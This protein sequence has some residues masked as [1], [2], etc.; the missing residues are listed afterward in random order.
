MSDKNCFKRSRLAKSI[1]LM[2]GS[3]AVLPALAQESEVEQ[4]QGSADEEV[5]IVQGIR[6]SLRQALQTKRSLDVVADVIN[7]DDVGKLPDNNI[8]E[9]LSR[10]PGVQVERNGNEGAQ[11]QLRGLDSV[12]LEVNGQTLASPNAEPQASSLAVIPSQLFRRITVLK[13]FS[14]DQVEGGLGGTVKFETFRPFDFDEGQTFAINAD[15]GYSEGAEKAFPR[16]NAYLSKSFEDT[17]AGDFGIL[18]AGGFDKRINLTRMASVSGYNLFGSPNLDVDGDGIFG[19]SEQLACVNA[20]GTAFTPDAITGASS[21]VA[22]E[23][24][25]GFN[26]VND[27]QDALYFPGRVREIRT[28]NRSERQSHLLT[29]QWRPSDSIEVIADYLRI[30][31]EPFNVGSDLFFNNQVERN[32]NRVLAEN[33]VFNRETRNVSEYFI[34]DPDE[35]APGA[36][37][38]PA[39]PIGANIFFG[40][41]SNAVTEKTENFNLIVDF[42][43]SDSI[44]GVVRYNR[45]EGN[46]VVDRFAPFQNFAT[47]AGGN[48]EDRLTSPYQLVTVGDQSLGLE[49]FDNG[50]RNPRDILTYSPFINGVDS[51]LTFASNEEDSYTADFDWFLDYGILESLEFGARTSDQSSQTDNLSTSTFSD[52]GRTRVSFDTLNQAISGGTTI[53]DSSDFVQTGGLNLPGAFQIVNPENFFSNGRREELRAFLN[54]QA[55]NR[56]TSTNNRNVNFVEEEN[57]AFYVKGNFAGEIGDYPY[58]ASFGLRYVDITRSSSSAVEGTQA[59]EVNYDDILPTLNVKVDL[60]DDLVFRLGAARNFSRYEFNDVR[61]NENLNDEILQGS[62]GNGLLLPETV[63][64]IDLSLEYYPTDDL[65][66]AAA[67]Y[68]KTIE[69]F[70]SSS[71]T[72][73]CRL[74]PNTTQ[75]SQGDRESLSPFVSQCLDGSLG[76]T[77]VPASADGLI[78][79]AQLQSG[80]VAL[81][82]TFTGP[83]N[84]KEDVDLFGIE[85]QY[86]QNFTFLPAPFDGLG[87]QLNYTYTDVDNSGFTAAG[88]E[89]RRRGLSDNSYNATA[90]YEK[91]PIEVRLA[92]NYRS[93]FLASR[94]DGVTSSGEGG[95]LLEEGFGQLEAS[96]TYSINDNLD[97]TFSAVNLLADDRYSYFD[98][99]ERF[100]RLR[101]TER[102]FFFG[103][104]YRL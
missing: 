72:Q 89:L 55:P 49:L 43:I 46:Q 63:N 30:E 25:G 7:S 10:V 34:G 15:L 1:V 41:Q 60:S 82:F 37:G 76:A 8:A 50:T 64:S 65:A 39:G 42:D 54:D 53:V 97:V 51:G 56:S 28:E 38:L 57:T 80:Q 95:E 18:Y 69:D 104:R 11:I 45:A 84:G 92:Y 14:A 103:V 9:A 33:I 3:A 88:N 59:S 58:Q 75:W 78:T 29:L 68:S 24:A 61:A 81:P 96:A 83:V 27:F 23:A 16:I 36:N 17:A 31:E 35:V 91:G 62:G 13:S 71:V 47:V 70:I 5:I 100:G 48:V 52:G 22:C 74:L 73:Q 21:T 2:L 102:T 67:I 66:F 94:G 40:S 93:D 85:L 86:Q 98:V 77:S 79:D 32:P 99:R 101:T 20:G 6:S 87:V 19:E 4:G 12:R 44:S 26:V 90:F